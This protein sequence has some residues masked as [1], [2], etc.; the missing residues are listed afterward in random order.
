MLENRRHKEEE[1]EEEEEL[2][3]NR[4]STRSR[5]KGAGYKSGGTRVNHS[6]HPILLSPRH[7]AWAVCSHQNRLTVT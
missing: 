5:G 1:E 6:V 7:D 2:L 4:D 3:S